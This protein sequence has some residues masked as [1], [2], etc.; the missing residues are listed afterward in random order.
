MK[1]ARNKN[2]IIN[3]L[4]EYYSIENYSVDIKE[5]YYDGYD[6][7]YVDMF[8]MNINCTFTKKEEYIKLSKEN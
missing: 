8:K 6:E 1:L 2:E 7:E 5:E 3:S 4:N